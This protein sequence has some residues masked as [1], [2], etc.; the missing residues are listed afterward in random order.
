M[1][2]VNG[3]DRENLD[4]RNELQIIL[5][6]GRKMQFMLHELRGFFLS[7]QLSVMFLVILAIA[8]AAD[9]YVFPSQ[10]NVI[11][12]T[13]YW[14]IGICFYILTM[15]GVGVFTLQIGKLIK[16]R[17]FYMPLVG[18]PV[19]TIATV[20]AAYLGA[21]FDDDVLVRLDLDFMAFL[22][23]YL[24]AQAFEFVLMN[25]VFSDY[26]LRR[27]LKHP[28][29]K[30]QSDNSSI[31][32][33][34]ANGRSIPVE[35]L[36]TIDAQQHYVT[37]TTKSGNL[38]VRSTMKTLVAQLDEGHGCQVHRSHWVAAHALIGLEGPS[39]KKVAIL[40][41]GDTR[42]VS[43]PREREVTQWFSRRTSS[44]AVARA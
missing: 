9:P 13:I 39:G 42:P 17:S 22:R 25:W 11:S 7:K 38:V 40:T 15:Y 5:I 35:N 26:M 30:L 4:P 27:R 24:L 21:L 29:A 34:T 8:V 14:A 3:M 2:R 10:V 32:T 12:R 20:F 18:V 1:E 43:R 6:N 36:I 44:S 37:I 31:A 28:P 19:V 16:L 41:S 33:I 23:N